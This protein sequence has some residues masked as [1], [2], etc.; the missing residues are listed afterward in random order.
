MQQL[1][2]GSVYVHSDL[3]LDQP[4]AH[5]R[6]EARCAAG[7]LTPDEAEKLHGWVDNGYTT[8]SLGLDDAFCNDLN[9]EVDA[10]WEVRPEDL[11]ISPH[12]GPKRSFRDYDGRVREPGYR[13]PDLHS[14]S[15]RALDLYLHPALFRMVE[16]IF[17]QPAIAFQ[18]IY[19]EHGSMQGLHRDPM[20]VATRPPLNLCAAWIALEDITADSG[21]LAY[22]PGSHRLPW[23]EF[24]QGT[25]ECRLR[26]P[27]ERQVEGAAWMAE[28]MREN[29]LEA[30]AFTCKRGDAFLWHAG[31]AH[32]GEPIRNRDRTR[33][34][35]VVHYSTA[36]DYKSRTASMDV[37]EDGGWRTVAR[38]TDVIIARNG[39][40]GLDSPRRVMQ[41]ARSG[42]SDS[43][44][45]PRRLPR[46][47]RRRRDAD[48]PSP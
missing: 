27:R 28:T 2:G 30:R 39:A 15:Q 38:T 24:E 32:G 20:F 44:A 45:S 22:V 35:F 10:L 40:R 21:P 17:D 23:F 36:A 7:M 42:L 47:F 3:W 8:I 46:L 9:S 29:G 6:I 13:I 41:E 48:Q 33:R 34:S 43:P 1:Q 26:V 4:D 31:L 12:V 37:R 18:S 5:D 11:A 14:H 16:L 25:I 19:F